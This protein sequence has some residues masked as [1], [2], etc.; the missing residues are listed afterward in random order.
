LSY[1]NSPAV[2]VA[3]SGAVYS[4][5]VSNGAGI[6]V[7]TPAVLTVIAFVAPSVVTHPANTSVVAGTAAPMCATFGG[8]PPFEVQ[9]TRWSGTA[10]LPVLAARRIDDNQ[11]ACTVTP[12]LQLADNGAQFRFEAIAGPGQAYS[13]TT[14]PATITVTAPSG[15]T[16]TTL[17]SRSTS[18]VTANNRSGEPSLSADGNLVAFLSDGTNLVPNFNGD[19]FTSQYAYVRNLSSGV[20]TL[21][22]QKPD[23]SRSSLGVIGLKLA[24]GGRYVIFTSL[25]SD[26][27]ADD[28]NGSQD[29]FV[30]DLQ[31]GTTRR[32][33]LR[34]D[35][36]ESPPA[37]NGQ[38]DM[39]VDISADGQFISFMSSNDLIDNG[40]PGDF[41]L[42]FRNLQGGFLERV[43]STNAAGTVGHSALSDSGEFLVYLYATFAPGNTR[44]TVVRF[45]AEA[46]AYSEVFSIDS[47]NF[48][49]YVA[50]GMDISGDGRYITFPVRSPT[51]FNGSTFTQVVALDRNNPGTI[52]V[53]SGDSNGFGNGHSIY[54]RVSDDGHVAFMTYAGNLT[55]NFANSQTVALAVRD[56]QSSALTV[57]SRRPNG[58]SIAILNGYSYYAISGDGTAV[59]FAAD[60]FDMSGG[61]NGPQIYVAPRP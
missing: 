20:T 2:Y 45:D 49:S 56:L 53:A 33:S 26:L 52:T 27:V 35:G 12:V 44:N 8:S 61:M 5:I 21:I 38:S 37:G 57:A 3:D 7:S 60:E 23:G 22:N 9:M 19:A 14:N 46:T 47:T 55:G 34:A 41:T 32:V 58:T 40:P 51:M 36:T 13:T 1:Y 11:P 39:H 48:A 54:P 15:I 59:A 10:W 29:V 42:Y 17:A 43:A 24:A 4:V 50:E 28:T 18:G 25:A 31:T 30:R 6:E 16:V